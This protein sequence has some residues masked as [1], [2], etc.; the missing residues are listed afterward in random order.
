MLAKP[1]SAPEASVPAAPEQQEVSAAAAALT[2]ESPLAPPSPA[3][4]AETEKAPMGRNTLIL[5]CVLAAEAA[6]ALTSLVCYFAIFRRRH[7]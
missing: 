3:L 7:D 4:P 6:V 5:L 2:A 1:E